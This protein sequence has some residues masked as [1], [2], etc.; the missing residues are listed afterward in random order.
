[1]EAGVEKVL[2]GRAV[3]VAAVAVVGIEIGG[4]NNDSESMEEGLK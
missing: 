2:G 3:V 4:G 1:V